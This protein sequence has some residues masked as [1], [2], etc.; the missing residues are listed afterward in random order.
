M[1][2][3]QISGKETRA[4]GTASQVPNLVLKIRSKT[5]FDSPFLLSF[6]GSLPVIH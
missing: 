2:E 6:T 5:R 3:L 4:K 1:V